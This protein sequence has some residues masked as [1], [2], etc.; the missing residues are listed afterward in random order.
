LFG[1]PLIFI[2]ILFARSELRLFLIHPADGLRFFLLLQASSGT[3]RSL[4]AAVLK[5]K[6]SFAAFPLL[7]FLR[8]KASNLHH[9]PVCE[10]Y[11]TT[12]TLGEAGRIFVNGIYDSRT[13]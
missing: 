4:D 1:R 9:V 2:L 10:H 11:V 5:Q 7:T 12:F 3:Q 13:G 8:Y 6:K